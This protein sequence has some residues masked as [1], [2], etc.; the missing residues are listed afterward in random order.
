MRVDLP[1]PFSPQ[2]AWISPR[3]TSRVTSCSALTPG[4][5]LVMPRISRMLLVTLPTFLGRAAAYFGSV[6]AGRAGGGE[7]RLPATGVL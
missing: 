3:S 1:A 7:S 4:N 2:M 5:V 6:T